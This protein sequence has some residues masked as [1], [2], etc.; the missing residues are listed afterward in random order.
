MQN[1]NFKEMLREQEAILID[2]VQ[3]GRQQV[4]E[5]QDR[6]SAVESNLKIQQSNLESIQKQIT[7]YEEF[8][9]FQA[10]KEGTVK[11]KTTVN[12]KKTTETKEEN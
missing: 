5:A 10:G 11:E 1:L 2:Y 4:T 6:L 3:K 12:R 9:K 7:D 8:E